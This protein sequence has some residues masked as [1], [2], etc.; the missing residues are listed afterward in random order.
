GA[1]AYAEISYKT[2]FLKAH[3]PAEFLSTILTNNSGYYSKMQYMEEARRLGVK[4]KLPGI[5]KG[6][7]DFAV[8]D[9][10][11]SI[12]IPLI[13]VRNLGFAAVNSIIDERKRN[14]HFRDFFDFSQRTA[15]NSGRI[16]K[17]AV[18]NLIKVGAFDFTGISRKKLLFDFYCLRSHQKPASYHYKKN[19]YPGFIIEQYPE[20]QN[21]NQNM[22]QME[23]CRADFTLEE[24]LEIEAGILGFYVSCHPLQ[25][26]KNELKKSGTFPFE[27][28]KSGLFHQQVHMYDLN[29][30]P[31]RNPC[32]YLNSRT[33]SNDT[34]KDIFS[35][36][37][38]ISK[39]IE[40]TKDNKN[41]LF[42]TMEDEDSMYEAVFFPDSYLKNAKIIAASPF[43]IIR[44][45]LHFK[46]NNVSVIAKDAISV[47][48]VKK[49]KMIQNEENIKAEFFSK[50]EN[51]WSTAN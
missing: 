24:K 32:K 50:T 31:A 25:H 39:R 5:N 17:N 44:G 10:G 28:I 23:Y 18:E 22:E 13:S 8:E 46:D 34:P 1:A 45:R 4:L 7:F 49:I 15:G 21:I 47:E 16:T 12:R 36:G 41:M 3:Y 43:L 19:K 37:I 14:G 2:C 35:A 48:A 26:F 38:V 11:K 27:I 9:S 33:V 29:R 20:N 42:C 40:K 6:G 51:L 30:Y